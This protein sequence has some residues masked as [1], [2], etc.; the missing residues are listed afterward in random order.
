MSQGEVAEAIGRNQATVSYWESGRRTPDIED[1]VSLADAL[2]V[3]VS[4]FFEDD[5]IR[6]PRRVI[7]RAQGALKPLTDWAEAIERIEETA[8]QLEPLPR[9]IRVKSDTPVRASEELLAQGRVVTPP[10]PIDRL[11][12]QCGVHVLKAELP[13]EVSGVLLVGSNVVIGVNKG[14]QPTRQRFTTAHELGHYLLSHHDHFHIDLSEADGDP[15][16]YNGQDER[17]ANDFAAAALMPA[18]MVT[19]LYQDND[20]IERLARRF[21]VSRAAMGWRLVNLGLLA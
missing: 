15:P 14:H 9:A 7:L 5:R 1:L 6:Q 20:S 3:D 19:E 2:D 10:I 12:T 13:T 11:A 21:K 8:L 4:F 16:G 17:A 18:P